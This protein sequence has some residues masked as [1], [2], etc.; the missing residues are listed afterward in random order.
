MLTLQEEAAKWQAKAEF[1]EEYG[2][3]RV[4]ILDTAAA[5]QV[6][7]PVS[8]SSTLAHHQGFLFAC[9]C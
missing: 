9:S 7:S 4:G 2:T 6:S 1:L 8:A 5:Q 3:R